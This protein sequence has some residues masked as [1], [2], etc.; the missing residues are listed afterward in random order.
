[1][2]GTRKTN[3]GR[4]A[5]WL[6]NRLGAV[7]VSSHRHPIAVVVVILISVGVALYAAR[8]LRLG[9]DLTDLVPSDFQSMRDIRVLQDRF[10]GIGYIAVVGKG[11]DAE[12][13]RRFA[14]DTAPRLEALESVAYV[15]YQRPVGFF[16]ERAL[17]YLD[18]EDLESIRDRI[19]DRYKWEK[20]RANPLYLD[21]EEAAPPSVDF[22]DI[23]EKYTGKRSNS[24]VQSQLGEEYYLDAEKG[25]VALLV[26]PRAHVSDLDACQQVV[27]EVQT[28]MAGVDLA[29]YG[30]GMEVGYAGGFVT[31]VD[32]QAVIEDDLNKA[33]LAAALLMTLYLGVHFRRITAI[34]LLMA[35]VATGVCWTFGFAAVAFG[36]LNLL[37]G[38]VAVILLGLGIDHGIH[39]L[40]RY[41]LEVSRGHGPADAVRQTY[42]HTGRA[43]VVAA[44]TTC[45]GFAGLGLSRFVVSRE[46]GILAAV[47]MLAV[48][49]AFT[50]LLPAL[51]AIATRLGWKP[52]PPATERP[53]PLVAWLARKPVHVAAVCTLVVV[54]TLPAI[55]KARFN[56]DFAALSNADLES[57]MLDDEVN[58]IIGHIQN[59][60][61]VMVDS[62]DEERFV[63][64]ALREQRGALGSQSLVG[65]VTSMGD[66]VPLQQEEKQQVLSSLGR[67]VR[68]VDPG[69]LEPGAAERLED[70]RAMTAAAPFTR[71][72]LPP[73]VVRQLVGQNGSVDDGVVLVFPNFNMLEGAKDIRFAAQLRAIETPDGGS[74][75]AAGE[76]MV[77][78]DLLTMVI[79]E[80][81]VV[82]GIALLL[83]F[84]C[85][86]FLLGELRTA[87]LCVVPAVATLTVALGLLD[88]VGMKLNYL[89]MVM[90]PV[91]FG[92]GVDGAVHIVMGRESGQRLG[93][94][95]R[96]TGRAIA[97]S[98]LT[99]CLGFG[100]LLL[101]H[102]PGLNSLGSLA[103][104]GFGVN[105]LI[106]LVA[107]PAYLVL[108]ERWANRARAEEKGRSHLY[109]FFLLPPHETTDTGDRRERERAG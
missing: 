74:I 79:A 44:L 28:A 2:Q 12:A 102:H 59:P 37:T 103:L 99:S 13:L 60:V 26:K 49:V 66:L 39:L 61:A 53:A 34:G 58:Q 16:E 83:V 17:Y 62:E 106:C 96:Q 97:A 1:M 95:L 42:T 100:A 19:Q 38:F 91:F 84:V 92:V 90:I 14:D 52:A 21:F 45:I 41:E 105:V 55:R 9:A 54:L 43:V 80:A 76:A 3:R 71:A 98:T 88:A 47:G 82:L 87:L 63:A 72:D 70:V 89:N 33:M 24:W 68:R 4:I 75:A 35:P 40:A 7:A 93:L 11:E 64:Q 94:I 5:D 67:I 25:L 86:W 109:A 8:D 56:S 108:R 22:A 30:R 6:E 20:R 69:W 46:L 27:A 32:Q 85:L 101:A 78:A 36:V 15:E 104:L 23:Q 48:V 107:M 18:L 10:G 29:S 50:V 65:S 57:I 73:T 31:R 81:P 77:W 51:L